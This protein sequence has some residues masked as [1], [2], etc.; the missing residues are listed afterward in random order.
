MSSD[1]KD[2]KEG[3]NSEDPKKGINSEDLKKGSIIAEIA[4]NL[5]A[6]FR[7]LLPGVLIIGAARITHPSWFLGFNSSS[8]PFLAVAATVAIAAGNA[9]FTVNRYIIH[10]VVDYLLWRCKLQG[11]AK[12]GQGGYVDHLAKYVRE[13]QINPEVPER[14]R[15]HVGFR[16]S[17]VLLI[18][19]LSELSFLAA[20]WSECGAV[21]A[22]L[23][24]FIGALWQH[25]ITRRI[26]AAV[27]HKSLVH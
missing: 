5:G 11:P 1:S 7:H 27:L 26:D 21:T 14:A 3:I 24:L 2:Q 16:A 18:Y 13:A 12:S 23:F 6:V 15:Q 20:F 25:V 17:S 9:W 10:Q 4:D 22:A 19:T 8:W